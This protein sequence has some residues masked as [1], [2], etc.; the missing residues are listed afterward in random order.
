M[1]IMFHLSCCSRVRLSLPLPPQFSIHS[2]LSCSQSCEEQ[3]SQAGKE[4]QSCL[5]GI[6]GV[7]KAQ[8]DVV[9]LAEGTRRQ[10]LPE[11]KPPEH[12]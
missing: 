9:Q 7:A 4:L 5:L 2:G 3:L 8:H 6:G 12:L 10:V 11:Q 1:G